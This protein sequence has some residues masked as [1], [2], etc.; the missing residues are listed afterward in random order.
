MIITK[1][2]SDS[3]INNRSSKF[4][5]KFLNMYKNCC[6]P[7]DN[8]TLRF[9]RG[10]VIYR[11]IYKDIHGIIHYDIDKVV[12][13]KNPPFRNYNNWEI[14]IENSIVKKSNRR[15]VPFQYISEYNDYDF[16]EISTI[17]KKLLSILT[18]YSRKRKL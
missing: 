17:N 9:C 13:S 14:E 4:K 2:I 7:R 3:I 16:K 10:N 1:R 15:S 8:S 5:Y 12:N 6:N 18:K 11:N